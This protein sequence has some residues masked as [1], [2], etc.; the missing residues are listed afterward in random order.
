M[1]LIFLECWLQVENKILISAKHS[2]LG[3][4]EG[5]VIDS[6]DFP[7]FTLPKASSYKYDYKKYSSGQTTDLGMFLVTEGDF[8]D[9]IAIG[10]AAPQ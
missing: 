4:F 9:L 3:A 6:A 7:S 1:I 10:T 5:K 2:R 8:L